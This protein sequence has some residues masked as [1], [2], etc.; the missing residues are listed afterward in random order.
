MAELSLSYNFIDAAGE[1]RGADAL[2]DALRRGHQA[3]LTKIDLRWNHFHLCRCGSLAQLRRAARA[4]PGVELLL[5]RR[6]QE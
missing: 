4:S 6:E 2:A 3:H 1:S 5:E